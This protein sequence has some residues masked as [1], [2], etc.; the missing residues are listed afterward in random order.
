MRTHLNDL[1]VV[2]FSV[3]V[4]LIYIQYEKVC[5]C[6]YAHKNRS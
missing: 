4:F 2:N 1:N 5:V 3:P 6:L